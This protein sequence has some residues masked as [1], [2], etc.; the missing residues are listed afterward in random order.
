MDLD[1][2]GRHERL[3]ALDQAR[4]LV[5]SELSRDGRFLFYTASDPKTGADIWYLPWSATPDLGRAVK[6][7][8]TEA[9]ESQA[10]LSPDGRWLAYTSDESGLNEIY[11]RPFPETAQAKRQ[12]SLQGGTEPLWAHSGRELF[13]RNATGDIVAVEVTTQPTF[14]AGRQTVLFAGALYAQDDTHRQYDVSPD[15]RRFLMIRERGGERG[16]LVLVDNWFQELVA[17]VAR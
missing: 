1:G 11:V 16:S 10:Q 7:L 4:S 17:K 14:A 2:G 8:G 12:V 13:Y 6:F 9:Q 3:L 15:D 5:P